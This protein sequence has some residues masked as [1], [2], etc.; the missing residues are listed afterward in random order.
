MAG[1]AFGL[2]R[3][4]TGQSLCTLACDASQEQPSVEEDRRDGQADHGDEAVAED[5]QGAEGTRGLRLR[6]RERRLGEE[7]EHP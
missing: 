2:A 3:V 7:R 1:A 5:A 4:R 6:P